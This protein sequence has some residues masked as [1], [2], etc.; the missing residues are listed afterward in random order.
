MAVIGDGSFCSGMVYEALNHAGSTKN[1]LIVI[2][3]DNE[4][5]ISENVGALARYLAIVRAKP[6]TIASRRAPKRR[7]TGYR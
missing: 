2:L 3:N 7:S 6:N 5:S 4:M 1:R